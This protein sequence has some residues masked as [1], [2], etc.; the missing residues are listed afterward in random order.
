MTENIFN[1]RFYQSEDKKT[2]KK[3][4]RDELLFR[5]L[6]SRHKRIR[7]I[8]ALIKES[9]ARKTQLMVWGIH[10]DLIDF[11]RLVKLMQDVVI[12]L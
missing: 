12:L 8:E 3:L 5:M 2:V 1:L 9:N 10:S 11:R 7:M 6:Q 4:D